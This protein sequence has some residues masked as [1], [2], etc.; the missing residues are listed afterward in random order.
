V[1]VPL[2]WAA[3]ASCL[4]A[5]YTTREQTKRGERGASNEENENSGLIWDL[6]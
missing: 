1:L 6:L 5:A 2:L 4:L 3:A